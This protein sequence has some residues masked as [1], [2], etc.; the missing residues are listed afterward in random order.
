V[1]AIDHNRKRIRGETTRWES[2]R[3]E[4][5]DESLDVKS[6]GTAARSGTAKA[7]GDEIGI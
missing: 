1:I 6:G 5:G 4:K 7:D 2:R 3:A